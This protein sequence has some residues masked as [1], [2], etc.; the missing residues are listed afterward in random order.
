M[1]F[2]DFETV[3]DEKT[4]NEFQ[5][6]ISN[7]ID[8]ASGIDTTILINH[9]NRIT[10][11]EEVNDRQQKVIEGLEKELEPDSVQGNL[12]HITDSA[13]ARARI[14]PISNTTQEI[15]EGY[16]LLKSLREYDQTVNGVTAKWNGDGTYTLNGTATS[17]TDIYIENKNWGST[18]EI[19]TLKGGEFYTMSLGVAIA[20]LGMNLYSF[21]PSSQNIKNMIGVEKVSFLPTNDIIANLIYV[22]VNSGVSLNN[23]VIKPMLYE[24]ADDKP[25][26]K[27]GKTPT[28]ENPSP[29]KYAKGNYEIVNQNKNIFDKNNGILNGKYFGDN[30]GI[31]T[32]TGANNYLQEVYYTVNSN[33]CTF[34]G[35]INYIRVCEYDSEKNFIKITNSYTAQKATITFGETT[36]Y[37]RV[38]FVGDLNS[39][40]IELG[41]NASSLVEHE[42]ETSPLHLGNYKLAEVGNSKDCFDITYTDENGYKKITKVDYVEGAKVHVFDG[43]ETINKASTTDADRYT[44]PDLVGKH[45]GKILS[46]YFTNNQATANVGDIWLSTGNGQVYF[47]FAEYNASNVDNVKTWLTEKFNEGNPIEILYEATNSIITEVTD[48]TLIAELEALLN[49]MTYSEITNISTSS[50]DDLEKA[51]LKLNVDYFKSNLARIKNI[52]QA[53]ISLGGNV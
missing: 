18:E 30:G 36:K 20:G 2:K 3:L 4:M 49:V 23:V 19:A 52:E 7:A 11:L 32:S 9:E 43:T 22:R 8:E 35:N 6:N 29:I 48:A 37:Y 17:Q 24:G 16:N 50:T 13:K 33:K 12:I 51:E 42:K 28:K 45:G 10:N 25:F 39:F 5:D 15:R 34:S 27:Y 26:E 53:I 47:N 31:T 14:T 38:S 1:E 46:N 40:Q 44:C 21:N 41:E